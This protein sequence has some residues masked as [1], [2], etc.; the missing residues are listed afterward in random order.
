MVNYIF[1]PYRWKERRASGIEALA[2]A[3][4]PVWIDAE[5]WLAHATTMV[6]DEA[7][8]LMGS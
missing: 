3:G 8:T 1:R 7:V 5:A 4:I 2:A 6:I